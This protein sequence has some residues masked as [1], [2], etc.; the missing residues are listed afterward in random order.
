L[1]GVVV[2]DSSFYGVY[3]RDTVRADYLSGVG[4]SDGGVSMV[5]TLLFDVTTPLAASFALLL[6]VISLLVFIPKWFKW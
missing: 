6:L 2:N 3:F 1:W 5:D 4:W